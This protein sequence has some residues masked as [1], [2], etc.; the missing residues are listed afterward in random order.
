[1]FSEETLSIGNYEQYG[2]LKDIPQDMRSQVLMSR[3]PDLFGTSAFPA[4]DAV[5]EVTEAAGA[6]E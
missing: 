4:D 6:G 2:H 5:A 1:M 3:F